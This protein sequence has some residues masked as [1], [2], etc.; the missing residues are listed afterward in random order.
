[1]L[2]SLNNAM[3]HVESKIRPYFSEYEFT[4]FTSSDLSTG[5][6]APKFEQNFHELVPLW[7]SYQYAVDNERNN[8]GALFK[9]ILLKEKDLVSWYANH[10]YRIASVTIASPGVWTLFDHDFTFNDQVIIETSG[11]LPT[12]L[13]TGTW[14]YVIPLDANTF[15]LSASYTGV[16]INTTG[17]Q[18]GT[19]FIGTMTNPVMS[20]REVNFY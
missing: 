16:A 2:I 6:A 18:S 15:M 5:T 19:H 14:Y 7:I 9:E 1:M 17:T 13:S 11:A 10:Q 3:E 20:M 12:G 4:R 8:A